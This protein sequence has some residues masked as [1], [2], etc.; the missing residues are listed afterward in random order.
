V[1][2]LEQV[3]S[4]KGGLSEA[5]LATLRRLVERVI[6]SLVD[7]LAVRV[8]P[9]LTGLSVPRPS[10]RRTDRLDLRRTIDANLRTVRLR[11][12]APPQILPDRLIFRTRGRRSMDWRIVLVVDTSGSMDSNVIHSAMMAAILSGLPAVSLHFVAFSTQVVD[13][14]ERASDPLGLL[15][16][17]RVGGGTDIGKAVRYARGLVTN[18][19]RTICVVVSDFEE[20]GPVRK[21]VAEVRTLVESGVK[22]LGLAALD[23]HARPNFNVAIAERLVAAGMPVA[24]LSPL[25]L[26][27]W[28]GE[29]I[30]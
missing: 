25:E 23:D 16:E 24:A 9:A 22:M 15:L 14:S 11:D 28:V 26:A 18:P 8:R 17:V 6:R 27:R 30:R 2:L 7:E 1:Q 12:D 19:T 20:G 5:Q 4:L 29:Q 21:L 13:L 3:L 10:R